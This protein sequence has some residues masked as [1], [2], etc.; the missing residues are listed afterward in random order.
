MSRNRRKRGKGG[1]IALIIVGS[2]LITSK[3]NSILNDIIT[4]I[5]ENEIISISL[6]AVLALAV[7]ITITC[8]VI[9]C[10]KAN[11]KK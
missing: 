7:A 3:I 5:R 10:L 1:L 8:V 11:K 2:I 6:L 9:S 4:V